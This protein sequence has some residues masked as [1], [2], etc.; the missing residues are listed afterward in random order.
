[1]TAPAEDHDRLCAVELLQVERR[2]AL[3][4]V[5]ERIGDDRRR[6]QPQRDQCHQQQRTP[7]ARSAYEQP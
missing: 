5:R 6:Q 1:L 7:R 4:E 3:H 2:I